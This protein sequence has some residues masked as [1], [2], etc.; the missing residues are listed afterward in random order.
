MMQKTME[1]VMGKEVPKH[2]VCGLRRQHR[3]A[4]GE[5]HKPAESGPF[6]YITLLGEGEQLMADANFPFVDSSCSR[7][8]YQWPAESRHVRHRRFIC[9]SPSSSFYYS[10]QT[11]RFNK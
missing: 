11:P 4:S 1:K 10:E 8:F 9:T 6:H 7:L 3:S 2:V 5:V